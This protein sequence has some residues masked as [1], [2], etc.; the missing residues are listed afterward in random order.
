[1]YIDISSN[2]GNPKKLIDS[3][4]ATIDSVTS[5]TKGF[6]KLSK[7]S[8]SS[9]FITFQIT[10][11]EDNDGWYTLTISHQSSSAVSP[12]SDDLGEIL[13]SFLTNGS[14]GDQG[15]RGFQGYTGFQGFTG[16]QGYTGSQ[17]LLDSR[18][19]LDFKDTLVSRD[20][21]VILDFKVI[22]DLLDSK[23]F[24]VTLDSKEFKVL[25]V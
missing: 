10:D 22:E 3:T 9:D 7:K 12:F 21:R 24:K 19:I 25:E 5:N 11:I 14:K 20:S 17:G 23:D 6:L 13:L 4:M 18:V 1:M 2:A 8:N 15:N 16:F